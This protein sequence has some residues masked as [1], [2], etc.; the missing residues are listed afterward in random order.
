MRVERG[1]ACH[2]VFLRRE[3]VFQLPVFICPGRVS[4]I[5]HLGNTAPAHILRKHLLIFRRC[6][7]VF[8]FQRFQRADRAHIVF[9]LGLLTAF[10]QVVIRNPIIDRRLKSSFLYR[11]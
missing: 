10:T 6:R 3:R 5:K 4:F 9:K 2:L 1:G 11:R 8:F 7:P